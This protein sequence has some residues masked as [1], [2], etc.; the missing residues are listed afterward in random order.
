MA[1]IDDITPNVEIE[2]GEV[3]ASTLTQIGEAGE[4][5]FQKL[6]DS[7]EEAAGHMG[8]IEAAAN[9]AGISVEAMEARIAAASAAASSGGAQ[10]AAAVNA[11]GASAAQVGEAF[12]NLGTVG[13]ESFAKI[14][15]AAASGNFAGIAT[16]VGGEVAGA[17]VAAAQA[18]LAFVDAEAKAAETLDNLRSA[19]GM[20]LS[21]IEG[22]KDAFASVGISASG[23]E[24]SISHLA[25]TISNEW[26][27]IQQNIR[28]GADAQTQALIGME[29]AALNTRKAYSAMGNTLDEV[30]RTAQH[31]ALAIESAT[32]GLTR[33]AQNLKEFAST[34]ANNSLSVAGAYQ[35]LERAQLNL[36][37]A[38]NPKAD[39]SAAE[40]QLH[41][42]E[43]IL[44]VE[45]AQQAIADAN[46]KKADE[47]LQRE[48]LLLAVQEARQRMAD[49]EA[50][51]LVDGVK[52]GDELRQS[53]L[54]V[55][56]AILAQAEA[57]QKAHEIDL[58]NIPA[59]AKEIENV[60]SGYKTW[61]S[62]MN[63]AEFSAQNLTKA[64]ALAAAGGGSGIP[65]TEEVFKEM[66]K[67]FSQMGDDSDSMA[68]KLEIVQHMMGA[69]FR[70][71]QASAVQMVAILDKG[72]EAL[73]KFQAEAEKFRKS[74]LGFK[75]EDVDTLKDYSSA[76]ASLGAI[77]DQVKG[78]FA[79][80]FASGLTKGLDSMRESIESDTG[81]LHKLGEASSAIWTAVFRLGSALGDL[82]GG[83]GSVKTAI[84]ETF[85]IDPLTMFL[86]PMKVITAAINVLSTLIEALG[87]LFEKLTQTTAFKT[88][89]AGFEEVK[90]AAQSLVDYVAGTWL[91]KLIGGV[92]SA[93]DKVKELAKANKEAGG[94]QTDKWAALP[95]GGDNPTPTPGFAA[96]GEVHGPGGPTADRAGLFALSDGEYVVKA[97]AVS[98][99]GTDLFHA[100]NS[101][102]LGG[103][104]SG[105]QVGVAPP[106]APASTNAPQAS[107]LN[108]TIDG[109]HFNGLTAPEH[110]A[111][112]LKTYAV[113]RQTSAAG[114]RPSWAS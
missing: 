48:S 111:S 82:F 98:H 13:A 9:R 38:Q 64:V 47:A 87:G 114:R 59:I 69:G 88:L 7:A 62:V 31:D 49:A 73:A 32:L 26:A 33:A 100:L 27:S 3:A 29:Q 97:A 113:G 28:T 5:A 51:R 76:A 66:S 77:L 80:I 6:G 108:L 4:A 12:K 19:T 104:A 53:H 110:V 61:A 10:A 23:F 79:A 58:K 21:E 20:T 42:K 1:G 86:I 15:T 106:R 94:G 17:F 46:Q 101:L 105:G 41:V 112:K 55:E 16:L 36:Q 75:Q 81:A 22:M 90:A 34:S 89:K 103:F 56:K 78:H 84:A 40:A 67:L 96:G 25:L 91:G 37:K 44:A 57:S 65:K 11:T 18:I 54:N 60:A 63:H 102:T 93:I 83:L 8:A 45:R 39:F 68:K 43:S 85:H 14:V 109:E 107:I 70:S 95:R 72:P 50:K 74:G 2:G 30:A 99:Y 52:A 92:S 24:R 71:G 35:S